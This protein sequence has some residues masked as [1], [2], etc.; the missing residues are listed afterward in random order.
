MA[1]AMLMQPT[2]VM[3]V[4]HAVV[5]GCDAAVANAIAEIMTRPCFA[6]LERMSLETYRGRNMRHTKPSV[7]AIQAYLSDPRC[8]VVDMDSG[9]HEDLTASARL[10]TGMIPRPDARVVYPA[11][12]EASVIVPHE[13]GLMGA[14]IDAFCELAAVVRAAA[15]CVSMELG[16]RLARCITIPL[17]QTA[18]EMLARQPGLTARRLEER[19]R[20]DKR[21]LDCEIPSPEWGLFLSRGH[22]EKVPASALEASGVFHQVRRL[23]DELVFL[24]LTADPADALRPDFDALLDPVRRVLA[25]VL[26]QPRA[27]EA[28]LQ[29]QV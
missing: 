20:Y 29:Q 14:R 15:G 17:L 9:R 27:D 18:P 13:R 26:S 19:S 1:G 24:Q 28:T 12:L 21:K 11:P 8:D 4:E 2:L 3:R 6:P 25:P 23:S 10:F 22:L 7:E 16:F 5:L